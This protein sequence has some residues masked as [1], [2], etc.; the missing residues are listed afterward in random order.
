MLLWEIWIVHIFI[1]LNLETATADGKINK[2]KH[3]RGEMLSLDSLMVVFLY[4]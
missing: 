4:L 1:Y 3:S 2:S